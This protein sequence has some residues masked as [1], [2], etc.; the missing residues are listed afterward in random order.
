MSVVVGAVRSAHIPNYEA[1]L[2]QVAEAI[3]SLTR[4]SGSG[5]TLAV[6]KV[7]R[8]NARSTEILVSQVSEV[9]TGLAAAWQNQVASILPQT[10]GRV[11]VHC[12][13]GKWLVEFPT[14]SIEPAIPARGSAWHVA[15]TLVLLG[16]LGLA[17]ELWQYKP[18]ALFLWQMHVVA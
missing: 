13:R 15:V 14:P 3:A 4:S 6:A 7:Q 1:T 16:L 8:G 17:V 12:S 11:T 5:N 2:Q 10:R 18:Y 9:S